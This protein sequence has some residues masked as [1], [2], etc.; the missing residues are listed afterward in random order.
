MKSFT[1]RHQDVTLKVGESIS[2]ARQIGASIENL[3]SYFDILEQT[4]NDNDLMHH[5]CQIFN[6]DETGVPLDAKPLKVL[7]TT[8]QKNFYSVSSGNKKQITV[9]ACVSA[10]GISLPPMIIFNRKGLGEGMD[11]GT[12][13]GTLFAFSPNGW[14]DTELFEDWFF[15]HFLVYAP[16]VRPL[17]LM[18][19]G[20][21]SHYSPSFISK[22]AEEKIIV[23][24]LPPNSTH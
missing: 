15:H 10:G 6:A 4:L 5:P 22:A 16:P 9:L 7:G 18:L 21:S 13:P 24:C 19:D 14:I 23:F 11:D 3:E 20:H 2:R 1:K 12:I 17:L 8:S